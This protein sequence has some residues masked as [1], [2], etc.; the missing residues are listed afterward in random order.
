MEP[1]RV[2]CA[3]AGGNSALPPELSTAGPDPFSKFLVCGVR[4]DYRRQRTGVPR[5][6]LRE[7]EVLGRPVDVG[8]RAVPQRVEVVPVVEGT[9]GVAPGPR[10]TH[11]GE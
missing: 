8:H 5:E 3:L 4:I 10:S 2:S 6:P 7:E 9:T 1:E 11:I